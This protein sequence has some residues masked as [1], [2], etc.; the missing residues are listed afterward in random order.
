MGIEGV[1]VAVQGQ[2]EGVSDD[3][4]P[5]VRDDLFLTEG[6]VEPGELTGIESGGA[7]RSGSGVLGECRF[8]S[9]RERGNDG[10]AVTEQGSSRDGRTEHLEPLSLDP[11][12]RSHDRATLAH[13]T[14]DSFHPGGTAAPTA[15]DRVL[16]ADRRRPC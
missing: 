14:R 1:D 12:P 7:G 5:I 2:P 3:R 4:G 8:W 16:R 11:I 15:V 10:G 9:E 6:W 13:V